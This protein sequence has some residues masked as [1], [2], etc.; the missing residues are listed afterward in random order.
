M[1]FTSFLSTPEAPV[2]LPD[3]SFLCVEMSADNGSV[4]LIG[5]DG[6]RLRT[7][8]KVGRPN[9][10]AM[11]REGKVW[12]AVTRDG[13]L[14]RMKMDG[15]YDIFAR[16]CN[17]L[18]FIFPNDLCFGPDGLLYMTDSGIPIQDWAPKE[19]VRPDYDQVETDGRVYCFNTQTGEAKLLDR[20]LRFANGIAFGPDGHLYVSETLT[21]FIYRYQLT[22]SGVGQREYFG[23]VVDRSL[24]KAFRGPDGM[25]FGMDGNLYCAV[26]GQQNVTV[27]GPDGQVVRRISTHG[28]NPTNLTFGA[29]HETRIYVTEVQFGRI[30]AHEVGVEG[31]PLYD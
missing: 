16:E 18:H 26:F 17:D 4:S 20:G 27:L 22:G 12:V 14:L 15:A 2:A 13:S 7:V 24:P 21:G 25:K 5:P 8:A 3:G 10:L 30:E 31:L 28:R 19:R 9:G 29:N 1:I 6:R 23:D 11:D